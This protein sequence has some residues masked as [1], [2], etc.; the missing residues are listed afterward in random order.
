MSINPITAVSEQEAKEEEYD[1][2][3]RFSRIDGRPVEESRFQ[4]PCG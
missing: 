2:C 4:Q 3:R 1:Q